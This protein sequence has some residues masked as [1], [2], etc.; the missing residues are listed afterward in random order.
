MKVTKLLSSKSILRMYKIGTHQIIKAFD[1]VDYF[2]YGKSKLYT[3]EVV[4]ETM[5]K[6]RADLPDRMSRVGNKPY[7]RLRPS[8]KEKLSWRA[9]QVNKD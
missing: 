4:K 1:G 3:E 6:W 5:A 2:E 7:S 9:I 8:S